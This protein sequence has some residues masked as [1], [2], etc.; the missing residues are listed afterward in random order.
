MNTADYASYE[1]AKCNAHLP[2]PDNPDA[3]LAFFRMTR[4]R[5]TKAGPAG[6]LYMIAIDE[7]PLCGEPAVTAKLDDRGNGLHRCKNHSFSDD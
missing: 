7:R 1:T 3:G 6:S 2:D 5:K 4:K